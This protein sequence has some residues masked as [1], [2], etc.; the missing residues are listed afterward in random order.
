MPTGRMVALMWLL[1]IH[2]L[3][4][5]KDGTIRSRLQLRGPRKEIVGTPKVIRR[6]AQ[7]F[8]F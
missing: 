6:Q 2:L 3:A 5:P 7:R 4:I 8:L 1:E